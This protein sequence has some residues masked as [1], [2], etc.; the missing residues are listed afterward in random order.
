MSYF[1]SRQTG[2]IV[3]RVKELDIIREFITNTLLMLI[4]DFSFIFIF[5]FAMAMFS[6]N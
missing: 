3:N 5:L 2:A 1:K 6:L 4:A